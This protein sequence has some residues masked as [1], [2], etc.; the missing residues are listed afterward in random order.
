M[1]NSEIVDKVDQAISYM[2]LLD[3]NTFKI[4]AFRNLSQQVE[5]TARPIRLSTKEEIQ[6]GFSKSMSA[7]LVSLLETES[8]DELDAL[9]REIPSGVRSMLQINGIGPKKV[10]TLW[11]EAGI[12]TLEEL[13]TA[14][15]RS[16][17]S[18]IKGFGLKI[19]ETIIQ[20]IVFLESIQGKILMHHGEALAKKWE[21]EWKNQNIGGFKAVGD[22]ETHHD[23]VRVM[24]FLFPK[25]E[26]GKVQ[27]WLSLN[28]DFQ[29]EPE[30]S[31]PFHFFG[32]YLPKNASFCFFFSDER[33]FAKN[34]F[35]LNSS[36]EHW[37]KAKEEAIPLYTVWKKGDFTSSEELFTKLNKPFISPELRE[38]TFEWDAE[39]PQKSE[40]L[41]TYKDLKG[42]IHNHSTYSDGKNTLKEMADWCIDQGWEYFG[43]AD[44][45]KT[46]QY[47]N[48][49]YEERVEAQWKEIDQL[50]AGFNGFCILK[51]I[52]SD[53]LS[54]GSLDY[55]EAILKG[56]DYVVASV[57]SVLKMD[58][59]TATKRL[60][61]AIENP[62]TR[63]LGH[64]SGRILLRRPGYPLDYPKIIDAC[65]AN[66]V[67]I[68]LNA[69]PSRLDMDWKLLASAL[70]KGATIAI[71]P[72]AHEKEGMSMMQYGVWLAR[73]AG[74]TKD[75]VLNAWSLQDVVG[76]FSKTKK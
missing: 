63:V 50:N 43:I 74:A 42:C 11:K 4:N 64:C 34:E 46:A 31:G 68:E 12:T 26:R 30:K 60:L 35:L 61:R 67:A 15:Q 54:D 23:T 28:P 6:A 55:E 73:K 17:V 2:E 3:Y 76:F 52:E 57:H 48:G 39:F 44:H 69:H 40:N 49:L 25:G 29:M 20:G 22:L 62:N 58:Q 56:F 41:I 37:L 27:N 24:E 47:A 19:Q 7:V 33:A 18:Q 36:A 14:C 75:Q 10:Q 66:Q 13:K 71:N 5:K 45:S 53:I 1:T 16:Q 32:T 72:D 21:E 9:E 59:E 51:G 65:I 38:G 8:F 70:E